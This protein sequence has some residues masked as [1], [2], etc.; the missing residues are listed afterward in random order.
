MNYDTSKVIEFAQK[1]IRQK[2]LSGEERP[3]VDL[4]IAHTKTL[5]FD[6]AFFDDYGNFIAKMKI[7]SG[8]GKKV[9]L[10]GHLDTVN[11]DPEQWSE[12]NQPFDAKIIGGKLFGR[13]SSDMKGAFASMLHAAH[14]LK[15]NAGKNQNGQ[16]MVVG[17]VVEE[18][19]EG[20]CFLHALEQIQPDYVIVGEASE[21]RINVGQRGRAEILI[22]NYGIGKHASIGRTTINP[23]EQVAYVIDVFHR[24]YRCDPVEL[25]GKRNIVPTDI[26]IPVGGGGGVDGRGGNSTVPNKLELTYDVR[27]LPGDTP[28]SIKELIQHE[29]D[30]VVD[31]AKD[32]YSSFRAPDI[33]LASDECIT[34][35]GV[36]LKQPKFASAWKTPEDSEIVIG[37][38]NGLEKAGLPAEI[39]SY[40]FCT[41][42]SAVVNYLENHPERSCQVIGFG[43]S[44]EGLAHIVNEYVEVSELEKAFS[45]YCAIVSELLA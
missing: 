33:T 10:T 35:T 34:H 17:T 3:V 37:A 18:L 12:D 38:L 22:T 42:G 19:F 30:K 23:I 27:T 6:E 13:G 7:G 44:E 16:I 8:Q 36:K 9:V 5:G 43:P 41:D 4:C 11:A 31:D 21:C 2:S 39:G 20:V 26:K 45:G 29:I 40:K 15:T 32:Q 24:Q 14:A 1:L 28:E 25:L